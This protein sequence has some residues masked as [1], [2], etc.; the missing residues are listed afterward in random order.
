[1][2]RRPPIVIASD[3]PDYKL[4]GVASLPEE[5]RM[6]GSSSRLGGWLGHVDLWRSEEMQLIQI[7]LPTESA[8]GMVA[9]LGEIGMLQFKDLNPEKSAFQRTHANAVRRCDDMQRRLRY[10]WDEGQG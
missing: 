7:M 6:S 9:A 1:M 4:V 8:H 3:S 2:R 10:Q 5:S